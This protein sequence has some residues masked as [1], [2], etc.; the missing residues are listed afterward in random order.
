MKLI[1]DEKL[2]HRLIGLA[3]I[4]SL[5]TIFAPALMRKSS[6]RLEHNLNVKVQLPPKPVAPDVVMKGEKDV[7]KTIKIAK[8]EVSTASTESQLLE[9]TKAHDIQV[10][11]DK[12][13]D[14]QLAQIELK[15][16]VAPV[17]VALGNPSKPI[18]TKAQP[19][20]AVIKPKPVIPTAKKALYSVQLASFAQLSNAQSLV[21]RL[22]NKGYKANFVR[23]SGRHGPV[24]KVYVGQAD[25]QKAHQLKMQ[26]ASTMQLNGFV[27]STGVS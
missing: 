10:E 5:A 9:T 16:K 4:I 26:L 2:K 23:I 8:V 15:P 21:N 18:L 6:Q 13:H 7:F 14:S 1:K 20:V 3:V 22:K 27:V 17:Q 12:G 11:R 25:R 19:K 24:Y